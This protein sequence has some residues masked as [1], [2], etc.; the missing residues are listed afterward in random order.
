MKKICS[1]LAFAVLLANW[2]CYQV[3]SDDADLRTVPVT[4]NPNIVPK[5]SMQG[6]PSPKI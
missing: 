2:G 4:N 5:S 6:I 1:I 3:H